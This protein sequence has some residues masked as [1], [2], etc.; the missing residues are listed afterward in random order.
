MDGNTALI[1]QSISH[2]DPSTG[3]HYFGQPN[4]YDDIAVLTETDMEELLSS[5]AVG[6]DEVI[7]DLG[8]S[9]SRSLRQALLLADQVLLVLDGTAVSRAKCE[10]FRT[11]HNLY[12][13]IRDKITVVA[14]R[15]AGNVAVEGETILTLPRVETDDPVSTYKTLSGYIG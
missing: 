6:T 3:I 9:Y 10:Q 1:F 15:G 7:V 12:A 5:C 11:Q 14:N 2:E 8:S 4:N 13:E